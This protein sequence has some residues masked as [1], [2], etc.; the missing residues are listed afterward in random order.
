MIEAKIIADSDYYGGERLTTMQV[1]MHRFVLSEFNTHRKFSRN[2]ASSRAIPLEKQLA[3]V[4][5]N[6]AMPLEWRREKSG[7][8]AGGVLEGNDLLQAQWVWEGVLNDTITIVE[9]YL[10]DHPQKETRLHKSWVNRLLEPFMWHTVCVSST[11][12]N[13]FFEQ[14]CSPLAQPE[15]KAVADEM[16]KALYH[17]YPMPVMT[18][19]EFH[20]PYVELSEHNEIYDRGY[21][22]REIS[23]ARCART[24]YLTQEG[25]RDLSKDQELYER[26]L[27]PGDGPPHWSP[28]EHVA[29]MPLPGEKVK[30]NFDGWIQLR[31]IVG[32]S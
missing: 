11:E 12:W 3:M 29:R 4:K 21:Y 30:G 31:Q 9:K 5:Q 13:N 6:P 1:K 22:P 16:K 32:G 14:R 24:S 23:T 8:Q 17:S 15:I 2:S 27:D 28:F 18:P 10:H 20:T 19:M 7:M 25:V 26:L